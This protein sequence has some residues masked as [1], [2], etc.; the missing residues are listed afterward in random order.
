MR[1]N[2]AHLIHLPASAA[3]LI[4]TIALSLRLD[5]NESNRD[6][7]PEM[8]Q[9]VLITIVPF[10]KTVINFLNT[11]DPRIPEIKTILTLLGE[12]LVQAIGPICSS[13]I[14]QNN[15]TPE[16][17]IL[18]QKLRDYFHKF[19]AHRSFDPKT[20]TFEPATKHFNLVRWTSPP[21][22][23]LEFHVLRQTPP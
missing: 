6:Y 4:P 2:L 7:D 13:E 9:L 11:A 10:A 3:T 14:D 1:L 8:K 5:V 18:I 20:F 23:R 16:N 12:L 19:Q 21:L 22:R 17:Q 15:L